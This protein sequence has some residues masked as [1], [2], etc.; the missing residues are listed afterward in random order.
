MVPTGRRKY[1]RRFAK[2]RISEGKI[3][4]AKTTSEKGRGQK[5]LVSLMNIFKDGGEIS[6]VAG[7]D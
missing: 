7:W 3:R 5:K 6:P 2:A 1:L 4:S